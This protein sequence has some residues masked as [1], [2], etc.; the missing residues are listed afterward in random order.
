VVKPL[1]EEKS[2]TLSIDLGREPLRLE[3]DPARLGQMLANLFSNSIKYSDRKG[4]IELTAAREDGG[5]VIR[6]KDQGIGIPS[7]MLERI[8][9]LFIQEDR[10]LERSQGGLGI[11]LSLVR[12]LAEM[13]GGSVTAA[14]EGAGEGSTFTLRLPALEQAD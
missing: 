4:R 7:D 11:G 2:H 8:F 10:S 14:S 5:I 9:D 12:Q 3:A 6:V 13:H 1:I